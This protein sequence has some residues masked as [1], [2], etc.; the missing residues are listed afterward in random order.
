MPLF[1]VAQFHLS[2]LEAREWAPGRAPRTRRSLG[3]MTRA[4]I[5]QRRPWRRCFR[6]VEGRPRRLYARVRYGRRRFRT[7]W[8]I[9]AR[10]AQGRYEGACFHSLKNVAILSPVFEP[11][12]QKAPSWPCSATDHFSQVPSQT[13]GRRARLDW[14]K[15]DSPGEKSA[16]LNGPARRV[17]GAVGRRGPLEDGGRWRKGPL[18]RRGPL[19]DGGPLEER[20]RWT[21][22]PETRALVE[23]L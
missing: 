19:E 5:V 4:S 9:A 6:V 7:R 18:G 14:P 15:V 13:F 21:R 23:R 20:G 17:L 12:S 3:P 16:G 11:P 1:F 10:V 8:G 22:A 2:A